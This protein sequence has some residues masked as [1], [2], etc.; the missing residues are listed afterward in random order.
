MKTGLA[1]NLVLFLLACP[2][3]FL[4]ARKV[5]PNPYHATAVVVLWA[6]S[7]ATMTAWEEVRQ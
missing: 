4:L 5:L 3:L 2:L 7:P 1:L 6:L